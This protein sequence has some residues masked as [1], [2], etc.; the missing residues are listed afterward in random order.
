MIVMNRLN[1]ENVLE[2]LDDLAAVER[3]GDQQVVYWQN[4]N[5]DVLGTYACLRCGYV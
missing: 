3:D 1:T 5:G 4:H 2:D